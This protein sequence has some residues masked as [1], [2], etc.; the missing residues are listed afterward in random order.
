MPVVVRP[1]PRR[2]CRADPLVGRPRPGPSMASTVRPIEA[3]VSPPAATRPSPS[4]V[5]T[6]V[7][8]SSRGVPPSSRRPSANFTEL[9]PTSMT[10]NRLGPQPSID[11]SPLATQTLGRPSSPSRPIVRDT[12]S[13]SGDSTATVRLVIPS[14]LTSVSSTMQ[15]ST[16][17]RRRRLWI[18]T[19][20]RSSRGATRSSSSCSRLRSVRRVSGGGTPSAAKAP[21]TAPA[22]S[23]KGAF[24]VGTHSCSPAPLTRCRTLTS[25]T[26]SRTLTEASP[27]ID[28]T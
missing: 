23:G 18:S 12:R 15:S 28:R 21:A 17:D 24:I 8:T 22:S 20:R 5:T 1:Y 3:A 2:R 19:A 4:L 27:Y 26:P 16:S 10:A 13:G 9:V 14:A 6:A 11:L 7:S 25:R